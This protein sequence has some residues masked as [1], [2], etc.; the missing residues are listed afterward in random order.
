MTDSYVFPERWSDL[1]GRDAA[2]ERDRD[3]LEA[4]LAREVAT[5]H[6]LSGLRASAVAACSHC[7]DVI[8]ELPDGGY[9]VVHLSWPKS[10]PDRPPWPV[11]KRVADWAALMSYID[12]HEDA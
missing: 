8:Y 12:D 2:D 10:A 6:P 11:H 1:R 7:D 3:R 5:S 9:A 4:E